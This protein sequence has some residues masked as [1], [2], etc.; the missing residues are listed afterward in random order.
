MKKLLFFV[1]M[2]AIVFGGVKLFKTRSAQKTAQSTPEERYYAVKTIKPTQNTLEQHRSFLA[3]IEPVKGIAISTKL[4]GIIT[5]LHVSENS[6]IKKGELLL[7]IDDAELQSNLKALQGQKKAQISDLKYTKTLLDR[8]EKLYKAGG[9]SREKY[10]ASLVM[11]QSKT[12]ILETTVQKMKQ[13]KI[14]LSYLN[15]KAPF[16]G[17]VSTLLLHE[18]DIALPG[19]PILKLHS[20]KQKMIFKY[21]PTSKEIALE[22]DVLIDEKKVGHIS[23]LY[24]YSINGLYLAEALFDSKLNIPNHSLISIEVLTDKQSGCSVPLNSL[25][26]QDNST[27]VMVYKNKE[28]TALNVNV[29]LENHKEA[30]ITPCPD[31]EVASASESKLDILA[32][33][34]KVKVSQ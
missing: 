4:T 24:D 28:F 10:D 18:G 26:H 33:L 12:A 32:S 30:I 8:N 7:N 31:S 1:I 23:K 27:S 29:L 16:S 20:N 5:H 2:A 14:Q 19:K 6:K 15:I 22:Q 11:Y 3:E 9:L 25:L 34:G 21:V 13:I 17:T